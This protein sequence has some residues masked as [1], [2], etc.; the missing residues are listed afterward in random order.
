MKETFINHAL[1]K[2]W[3]ALASHLSSRII[4]SHD[5]DF[6][7]LQFAGDIKNLTGHSLEEM[8]FLD[9]KSY[10]D[11]VH[12]DDKHLVESKIEM[13]L[14]SSTDVCIEYR[15]RGKTAHI[16]IFRQL[17]AYHRLWRQSCQVYGNHKGNHT[18]KDVTRITVKR[19]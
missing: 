12:P 13:V 9:L 7:S 3:G 17:C 18:K 15:F 8:S 1:Y 16:S 19:T 10:L 2:W 5:K 14:S 11:L 6:G 4:Y